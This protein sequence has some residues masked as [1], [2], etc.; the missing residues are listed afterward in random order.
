MEV[1]NPGFTL[2]KK[3]VGTICLCELLSTTNHTNSHCVPK[4][5]SSA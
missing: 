3:A 4:H 1:K 2:K 5:H